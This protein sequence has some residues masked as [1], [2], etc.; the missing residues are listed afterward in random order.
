MERNGC[1]EAYGGCRR[2]WGGVLRCGPPTDR[3]SSIWGVWLL[4]ADAD[5]YGRCWDG[6]L[7]CTL[8]DRG[9]PAS[10]AQGAAHAGA[11]QAPCRARCR[12][13]EEA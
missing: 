4:Q 11:G 9:G 8:E 1:T 3:K 2:Y 7:E 13:V 6:H 12:A 5:P 10:R